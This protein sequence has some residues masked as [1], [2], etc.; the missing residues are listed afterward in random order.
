M[1]LCH[2]GD[3]KAIGEDDYYEDVIKKLYKPAV[4]THP[5]MGD[6]ITQPELPFEIDPAP[7]PEPA[8]IAEPEPVVTAEP[9]PE[10]RREKEPTALDKL[11]T[12]LN[13]FMN[14]VQNE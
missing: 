4:K 5:T 3:G 8:V 10:T 6:A 12:W 9:E 14:D 2:H 1:R 7:E 13:G 11:K